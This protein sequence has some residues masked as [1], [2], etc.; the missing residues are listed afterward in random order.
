MSLVALV[1]VAFVESA[2]ATELQIELDPELTSVSFRL[3]ATLHSVHGEAVLSTG[4][5]RLDSESGIMTGA[6]SID[7]TSAETGNKKRDRK[8]HEKVL[9][10]ARHPE[11][12]LQAR[13]LKGEFAQQG[14]SDVILH[15]TIQILGRPH[16]VSIPM[17]I[18]I[19]GGRFTASFDFDIPYVEWGLEDPSTFVLRVAK[20]VQIR[21]AARGSIGV[22]GISH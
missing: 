22:P 13:R 20:T 16:E 10:T 7:A 17:H 5:L 15:G 19:D 1:L 4:S 14:T 9:L 8:M 6:V 2:A 3:Q 18:E 21:I 12:V 11:I